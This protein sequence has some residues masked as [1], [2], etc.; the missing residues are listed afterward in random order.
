MLPWLWVG[1]GG[2]AGA[3]MRYYVSGWVQNGIMTFPLGT[4]G[5]NFLGSL[6]LGLVM[7]LSEFRGMFSEEARVFLSIGVLGAFTTMSTFGYESLRL[8]E[9]EEWMLFS[10]NVLGSVALTLL[11]VYLGRVIVLSIA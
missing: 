9:Q 3:V 5:V 8:L 7:Y 11:G 2:F 4:L 6:F 10:A 1:A